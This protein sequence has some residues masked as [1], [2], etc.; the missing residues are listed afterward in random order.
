MPEI[1]YEDGLAKLEALVRDL[2]GSELGLEQRLKKFEE[3]TKLARL[4]MKKLEKAQNKVEVLIEQDPKPE[5]GPF[6]DDNADDEE[7]DLEDEAS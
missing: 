5:Y 1:Q 7:R 4:L 3:G 6:D 2:D